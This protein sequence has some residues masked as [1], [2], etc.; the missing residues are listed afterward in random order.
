ME[1]KSGEIDAFKEISPMLVVNY[2]LIKVYCI[3]MTPL[4]LKMSNKV[5]K[6]IQVLLSL[7]LLKL[8]SK[9]KQILLM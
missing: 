8:L 4:C 6:T 2:V 9:I 3:V 7:V 5:Q 1:V